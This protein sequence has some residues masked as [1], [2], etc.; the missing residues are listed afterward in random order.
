MLDRPEARDLLGIARQHLLQRILPV[1]PE[2]LRYDALM[3]AN[4]LAI[5][6]REIELAAQAQARDRAAIAALLPDAPPDA[7][8]VALRSAL[9]REIRRGSYDAG[10]RAELLAGLRASVEARLAISNPKLLAPRG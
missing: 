6:A 5:A 4:A 10:R 8:I 1:L 2:A 3:V 9:C 7:E